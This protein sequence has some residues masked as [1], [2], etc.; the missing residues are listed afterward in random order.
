[1]RPKNPARQNGG[2]RGLTPTKKFETGNTQPA[3]DRVGPSERGT[4]SDEG[5]E[6]FAGG[7]HRCQWFHHEK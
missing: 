6:G 2:C 4:G 3:K 7:R 1:M 5:K